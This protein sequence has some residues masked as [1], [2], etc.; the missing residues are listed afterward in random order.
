MVAFRGARKRVL[1]GFVLASASALGACS[2]D[3]SGNGDRV[4]GSE[5]DVAAV[6]R[7]DIAPTK[8]ALDHPSG[9]LTAENAREVVQSE[10]K[11]KNAGKIPG[12]ST[13]SGSSRQSLGGL[14][15]QTLGIRDATGLG[16]LFAG[17]A[18]WTSQGEHAGIV[19]V[20]CAS[21]GK[22][23]GTMIVRSVENAAA[24]YFSL[25]L[26]NVCEKATSECI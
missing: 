2:N 20:D 23:T 11:S 25:E 5:A 19:D 10:D 16:G 14:L 8:E 26:K 21:Q 24:S 4:G 7:E 13:G 22:S 6:V 3:V 9:T 12:S 15:P 1:L 18:C 17:S